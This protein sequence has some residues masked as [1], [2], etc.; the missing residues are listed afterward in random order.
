MRLLYVYLLPGL[1]YRVSDVT[2]RS[3]KGDLM[4]MMM[5]M[6]AQSWVKEDGVREEEA[7]SQ[8]VS[9]LFAPV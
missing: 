3:R 7:N 4:M 2:S 5:M 6:K 8:K 1:S 9:I